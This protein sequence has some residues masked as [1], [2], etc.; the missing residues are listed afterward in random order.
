MEKY[1]QIKTPDKKV[2]YGTLSTAKK[3]NSKI[4]IF[5]HGFLGNQNEHIFFNGAKFFNEN[6]FD[7]FRY[8][9]FSGNKNGRHFRDTKISIYGDDLNVVIKHFKKKYKDIYVV[10]HSYGGTT[11][12]FTDCTFVNSLV[13]W[14][15]SYIKKRRKE[16]PYNKKF[17]SFVMDWGFEAIVGK[18]FVDELKNFP[19]CGKMISKIHVPVK[20][21]TAGKMGNEKAGKKYFARANNPK[22]IAN[23]KPANHNFDNFNDEK[24]LFLE[25]LNW[26]KKF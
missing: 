11:L 20:F 23:I 21:I 17:K 2:I 13:F 24:R 26:I 18:E 12:L 6:G 14:D 19:D 16:F 15:A 3:S 9:L 10:G 4:V 5:V 8:D 25:T 22:E 1:I 7:A